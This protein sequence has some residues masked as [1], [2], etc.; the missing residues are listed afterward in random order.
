MTIRDLRHRLGL[1]VSVTLGAAFSGCAHAPNLTQP[2]CDNP[3]PLVGTYDARAPGYMILYRDHDAAHRGAVVYGVPPP[4]GRSS[5]WVYVRELEPE[6][7]SRLRCDRTVLEVAFDAAT[8]LTG[9]V[10]RSSNKALE[11]AVIDKVAYGMPSTAAAQR[12]R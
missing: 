12:Q 9:L 2:P 1:S 5:K 6:L 8:T 10:P 7:L 4:R 11:R 3:A